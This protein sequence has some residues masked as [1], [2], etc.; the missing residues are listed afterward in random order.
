MRGEGAVPRASAYRRP[1]QRQRH[2][3]G[4]S[5]ASQ[6]RMR[7]AEF[8]EAPEYCSVHGSLLR[9]R[10]PATRLGDGIRAFHALATPRSAQAL[11][12]RS[13]LRYSDRRC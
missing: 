12:A 5:G 11:P 9:R 13:Q 6:E 1:L 8:R 4:G 3:V 7:H 2:K 10:Q